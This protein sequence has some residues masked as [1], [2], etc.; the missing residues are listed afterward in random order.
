MGHVLLVF[1][2]LV[3][4]TTGWTFFTPSDTESQQQGEVEIYEEV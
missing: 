1:G 4:L 2:T 3:A